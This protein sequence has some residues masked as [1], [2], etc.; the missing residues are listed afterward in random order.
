M[1]RAQRQTARVIGVN[2]CSSWR[3]K[4]MVEPNKRR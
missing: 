1:P 4:V 2:I 3:D